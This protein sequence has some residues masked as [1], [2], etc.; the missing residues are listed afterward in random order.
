MT[1]QPLPLFIVCE[2]GQ[3]YTERFQRFLHRDFRFLRI[4]GGRQAEAAILREHPI[5]LLVDLDFRRLAPAELLGDHGPPA[6]APS[7]EERARWSAVQGILIL[8]YLR[9]RGIKIPALLF[10]DLDD[11]EQAAYLERTLA[12]LT[13]ASSREGLGQ[14]AARLREL[15]SRAAPSARSA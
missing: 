8:Q 11:P 12:P 15:C 1:G 9:A 10:A 7:A 14:L 13:I 4:S 3:E 5:G 2:D 6:Q